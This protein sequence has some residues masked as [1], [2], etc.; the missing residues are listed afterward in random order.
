M[1]GERRLAAHNAP[2]GAS[3]G[4]AK[5]T[6]APPHSPM[7]PQLLTALFTLSGYLALDTA[8]PQRL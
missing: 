7:L 6:C 4:A 2:S 8:S 1:F 5:T 3:S